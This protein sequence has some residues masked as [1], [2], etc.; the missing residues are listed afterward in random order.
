MSA[1]SADLTVK[2]STKI[3]DSK[4]IIGKLDRDLQ[5]IQ[6]IFSASIAY[7]QTPG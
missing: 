4:P 5:P 2:R 7:E 6:K 3:H 1:G